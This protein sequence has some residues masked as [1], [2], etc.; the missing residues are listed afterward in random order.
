VDAEA[1]EGTFGGYR[2]VARLG[3]GSMGTVFRAV[4]SDGRNVALKVMAPELSDD[5]DLVE[6]FRR[7]A[8]SAASIDH[9]GVTRV[10][11]F[12]E[13]GHRLYMVME[14]LDGSD[15]KVLIER[16]ATGPL[17]SRLAI[18]EQ[19]SAGMA[20]VHARG[21]VHRDLKPGNIHVK[22]DGQVKIM[23]FGLVRTGDSKMTHTG[24]A[25]GSPAYMAPE[26]LR[27]DKA[28]ARSD[29][30]SLGTVF[31][32]LLSG[33]RAFGGKVIAQI[34]MA[35]VGSEPAPLAEVAPDVPAPVAGLVA[36]CLQKDPRRRY[37]TGGE[38]HAAAQIAMAV[39][40]GPPLRPRS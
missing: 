33:R 23:D 16:G 3:R 38:L 2:V 34:L 36:R 7:E 6:R 25:M 12:G 32:E 21:L 18:I 31:Y 27:G 8:L 35:V 40:G 28:D 17:V 30:F 10:Y 9:P 26:Q 37:Q 19:V 13:E 22:Q 11:D 20:A 1:A 24:M 15:L 4:A 5:P 14:L 39:Y 29:I